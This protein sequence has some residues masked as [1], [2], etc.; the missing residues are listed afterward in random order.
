MT[1]AGGGRGR[2]QR[3]RA[4]EA[5]VRLLAPRALTVHEL[6]ARLARRGYTLEEARDAVEDLLARGFL[7]DRALAYNV[8]TTLAERRLFGK[9][10][11]AAELAR[12]GVAAETIVEA[13]E[14]AF[15]G[16]DEDEMARKAAGRAGAVPVDKRTRERTARALLRR[17]FSRGAVARA[18]ERGGTASEDDSDAAAADIE[19]SEELR[20][21]DDFETD[22]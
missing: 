1:R 9:T 16:L 2:E 18:L 11:V 19:E 21:D 20:H 4:Y 12:R 17:G 6:R 15:A 22:S 5:A 10:R 3:P 13:L 8:A 14:R 7:D